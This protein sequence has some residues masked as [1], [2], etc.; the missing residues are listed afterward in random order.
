MKD[1]VLNLGREAFPSQVKI[2]D[3]NY[4]FAFKITLS[5]SDQGDWLNYVCP[6]LKAL[7]PKAKVHMFDCGFCLR[8]ECLMHLTKLSCLDWPKRWPAKVKFM[9]TI[10]G[11]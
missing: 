1:L 9:K 5:F 4:F 7:N 6:Y 10:L 2:G 3:F 11:M 8:M